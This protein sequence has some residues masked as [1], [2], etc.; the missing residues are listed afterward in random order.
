MARNEWVAC[1]RSLRRSSAYSEGD[2]FEYTLYYGHR[3]LLPHAAILRERHDMSK[4]FVSKGTL[5]VIE[6]RT[7]FHFRLISEEEKMHP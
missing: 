7:Q 6:K 3:A 5:H 4:Q 1:Y 2:D